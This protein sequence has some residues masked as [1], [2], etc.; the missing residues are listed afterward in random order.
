MIDGDPRKPVAT[1]GD[2]EAARDELNLAMQLL[3]K[4]LDRVDADLSDD[5]TASIRR[6]RAD[7]MLAAATRLHGKITGGRR[8]R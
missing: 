8:I 2:L 4:A 3:T 6:G 7:R 1:D 5:E